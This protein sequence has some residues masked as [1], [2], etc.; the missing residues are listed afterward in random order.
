VNLSH[1][2]N[3]VMSAGGSFSDSVGDFRL[4]LARLGS[5]RVESNLEAVISDS[6]Y[7][8]T[9]SAFCRFRLES[10]VPSDKYLRCCW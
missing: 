5:K 4:Y 1:N 7:S 8:L 2:S 10:D 9:V 6:I 3:S